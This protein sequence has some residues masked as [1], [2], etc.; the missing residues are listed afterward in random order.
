MRSSSSSVSLLS[1]STSLTTPTGSNP[2]GNT[3]VRNSTFG[4][5]SVV[6]S[7]GIDVPVALRITG[8]GEILGMFTPYTEP[9]KDAASKL[10]SLSTWLSLSIPSSLKIWLRNL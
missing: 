7:L 1:L 2:Q 6:G 3:S 10:G 9:Q 4:I 8:W 5:G